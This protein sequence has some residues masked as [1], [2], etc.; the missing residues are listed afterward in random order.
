MKIA[1]L[2]FSLFVDQKQGVLDVLFGHLSTFP[3]DSVA[4]V[5]GLEG[6]KNLETQK[7]KYV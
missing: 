4:S 5:Y 3:K 1:H 7:N 6:F 2:V